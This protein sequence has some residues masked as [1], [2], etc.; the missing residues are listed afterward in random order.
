MLGSAEG[1]RGPRP[2]FLE[3]LSHVTPPCDGASTS[4][5]LNGVPTNNSTNRLVVSFGLLS[6]FR[7]AALLSNTTYL[8]FMAPEGQGNVFFFLKLKMAVPLVHASCGAP[9]LQ[10]NPL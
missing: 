8:G 2:A 6:P 9:Q 4:G 3:G 10:M 5:D 1:Q 7:S